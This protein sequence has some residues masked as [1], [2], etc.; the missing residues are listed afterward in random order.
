MSLGRIHRLRDDHD[1]E[2]EGLYEIRLYIKLVQL[3]LEVLI[4]VELNDLQV[5]CLRTGSQ[6]CGFRGFTTVIQLK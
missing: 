2:A 3:G 5:C 6:V 4:M 1:T